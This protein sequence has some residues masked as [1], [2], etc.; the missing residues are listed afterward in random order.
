MLRRLPLLILLG[1]APQGEKSVMSNNERLKPVEY[2]VGGIWTTQGE[3]PGLGTYTAERT[4]RLVLN[5]N[6]IEQRHVM[7][8]AGGEME[9]KGMIGW[10]AERKAIV[11]WGF[12]SDGGVGTSRAEEAT[13]T[14]IRFEGERSGGFNTGPIRASIKKTSADEFVEVAEGKKGD[15][16]TPMFTFHFTRETSVR[17]SVLDALFASEGH[18]VGKSRLH[19]PPSGAPDD[20]SSTVMVAPVAGGRFIRLDYTW[21]YQKAPQEGSLLIGHESSEATA[22]WIDTWHMGD[23]AMV[24]KGSVEAGGQ[25]TVRGSY[26]APP[27]PDWG[28]RI[29]IK[30]DARTLHIVM[31]NIT[32]KGEE[33]LAV[34][35]DYARK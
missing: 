1:A 21:A 23:K 24:C 3:M 12:G 27:G 31:H 13:L 25:V 9:T 34:E 6:F 16:W 32:P 14:E 30:P 15:V 2:L 33:Q 22:I 26:A 10:D 35:A 11:G 5:G 8:F 20:S 29:V 19:Y 28:W 4:Y 17:K 18:W 7:K